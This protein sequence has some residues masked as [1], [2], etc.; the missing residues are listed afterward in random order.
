MTFHN[1]FLNVRVTAR[2][3]VDSPNLK[4]LRKG[5]K[6]AVLS[7]KVFLLYIERA[8]RVRFES[9]LLFGHI[10]VVDFQGPNPKQLEHFASTWALRWWA[11]QC[12]SSGLTMAGSAAP[13]LAFGCAAPARHRRSPLSALRLLSRG[14]LQPAD[15]CAAWH[16]GQTPRHSLLWLPL[17]AS[18][19]CPCSR[20]GLGLST[21][22]PL[23]PQP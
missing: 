3:P 15:I 19:A 23:A 7:D 12:F 9:K 8:C 10:I 17:G 13:S 4:S 2:Q 16:G 11:G 1:Q 22:L 18:L 5:R 14:G 20:C 6:K 21:V